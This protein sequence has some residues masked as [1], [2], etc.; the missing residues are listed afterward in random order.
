[1]SRGLGPIGFFDEGEVPN[2]DLVINKRLRMSTEFLC[3]QLMIYAFGHVF[4]YSREATCGSRE[5]LTAS[6]N[7]RGPLIVAARVSVLPT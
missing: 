5:W 2:T 1:M 3:H 6:S 7:Q 4:I